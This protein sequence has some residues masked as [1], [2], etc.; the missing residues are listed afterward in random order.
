M[1]SETSF[2]KPFLTKALP[3]LRRTSRADVILLALWFSLNL[4]LLCFHEP[5]RDEAEAFMIARGYGPVGLWRQLSS[6]GQPLLWFLVLFLPAK[7]GIP[8]RLIG[9]ISL[10]V[11][12]A[13]VIRFLRVSPLPKPLTWLILF[14]P[15]FMYY[16]P[17]ISRNYCLALLLCV[18]LIRLR[19]SRRPRPLA[20]G[21]TAALLFQTHLMLAGVALGVTLKLLVGWISSRRKRIWA[22]EIQADAPGTVWGA[23]GG[24]A[25]TI[26]KEYLKGFVVALGGLVLLVLEMLPAFH[27]IV[28]SFQYRQLYSFRE[29][30][31]LIFRTLYQFKD[32]RVYP[33]IVFVVFLIPVML[34][35]PRIYILY[36]EIRAGR[37]G[38]SDKGIRAAGWLFTTWLGI[39][40]YFYIAIYV[41]V[42]NHMQLSLCLMMI[43]LIAVCTAPR[44]RY[45]GYLFLLLCLL[46]VPRLCV[47]AYSDLTGA[48]SQSSAMAEYIREEVPKDAVI[49]VKSDYYYTPVAAR[50]SSRKGPLFLDLGT[51][52][53][54]VNYVWGFSY[55]EADLA[56]ALK[57]NAGSPVYYLTAYAYDLLTSENEM[58]LV[59]SADGDTIT[60]EKYYLY[61]VKQ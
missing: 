58:E 35:I 19:R 44:A 53:R 4:V 26:D 41:R 55:P 56:A 6:E 10:L 42:S 9:V 39:A 15:L 16:N 52:E 11:C 51:G 33:F 24:M 37:G 32:A 14:S 34:S 40:V 46:G 38:S 48:Y 61:R 29:Q 21:V 20:L 23:G 17:V 47:S 2:R 13:A 50:F 7:L 27:V 49:T 8:F 18:Q 3:D 54:Y 22:P 31:M 60:D 28:E 57:E 36:E 30:G 5:W 12:A 1:R 45:A 59:F 25:L 43:L